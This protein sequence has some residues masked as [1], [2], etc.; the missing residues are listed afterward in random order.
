M[1]VV[2]IVQYFLP[3]AAK[4]INRQIEE[5]IL[6]ADRL[7]V[8]VISLAALNKVTP[9]LSLFLSFNSQTHP[10]SN[11]GE[12]F[13]L[14]NEALN[15]GGAIFVKKHPNLKVRVVHG[16]TLT[17][18]VILRE[19][20]QDVTEV[21]LTGATSKL[22]RAIA[23]YLCRKGVRVLVSLHQRPLS[24]KMQTTSTCALTNTTSTDANTI[25][26]EIPK[27]PERGVGRLPK[28]PCTSNKVS[29]CTKLQD[30]DSRKM[31]HTFG[32]KIRP[33]RDALP[34]VCRSGHKA[35]Q[36]GLHIWESRSHE[37]TGRRSRARIV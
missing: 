23:L 29:S 36:K 14:Q 22:G 31:D 16:N 9:L 21:F 6:R 35:I 33:S 30:M 34:P 8:K 7:G 32:A 17:A 2:C 27:D 5:A 25:D 3:F 26:R 1:C 28:V 4:G 37:A 19:L 10:H 18:A 13:L 12:T 15:G 24:I 11:I 20:P